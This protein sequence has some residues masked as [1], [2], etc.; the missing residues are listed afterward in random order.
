MGNHCVC[1]KVEEQPARA[2]STGSATQEY[3]NGDTYKGKIVHGER[4]GK[5]IYFYKN[6]NKYEGEFY[7]GMLHGYGIFTYKNGE[8]YQG[9]W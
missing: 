6:G 5:G 4:C 2:L 7:Q 1:W 3:D 8:M 9:Q